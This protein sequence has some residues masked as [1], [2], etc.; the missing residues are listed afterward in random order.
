M[1]NVKA[2]PEVRQ[3]LK[4]IQ[5]QNHPHLNQALIALEFSDSKPYVKDRLNLGKV[6][7]FPKSAKLWLSEKYD[8]CITNVVDVWFGLL[9][10][11]QKE[12]LLDLHL[13][14]CQVEY[15]KNTTIE[16]G[17]KIVIKDEWGRAEYTN[18][19]RTDDEGC[20]IWK[21]VK[22]DAA[23]LSENIK[24]YGVWYEDLLQLKFAIVDHDAKQ[25]EV[26]NEV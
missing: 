23:V 7:K 16:N 20:P 9:N 10:D 4:K 12:A 21:A 2:N 3:L 17:K 5:E 14:C 1:N 6:K 13:S 25:E 8:F 15:E 11:M 19:M 22:L 18:V 24:R 26:L